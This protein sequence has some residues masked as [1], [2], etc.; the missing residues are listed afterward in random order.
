MII[1]HFEV[2]GVC[3]DVGYGVYIVEGLAH[4]NG[5]F[6]LH[7]IN[8]GAGTTKERVEKTTTRQNMGQISVLKCIDLQENIDNRNIFS[9]KSMNEVIDELVLVSSKIKSNGKTAIVP[10]EEIKS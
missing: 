10:K 5:D 9:L 1:E 7:G 2:K 8:F 4:I 6:E 3:V